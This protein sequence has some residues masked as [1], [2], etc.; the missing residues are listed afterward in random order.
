M[1]P[2]IT[3]RLTNLRQAGSVLVERH[4]GQ[5]INMVQAC[6]HS[7]AALAGLLAQEFRSFS[8]VAVYEGEPVVFLKRAQLFVSDLWGAFRGKGWGRF[9]DMEALTAFA[10][11]KLPQLL[12][13]YGVLRY[14]PTLAERIDQRVIIPAGSPEEVEIRAAT[15]QAVDLLSD[16]LRAE[17]VDVL[18]FQVDWLLWQSAQG[19]TMV[20]PYH[21]TRTI[22]Y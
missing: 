2:M 17:G 9:D 7:A 16:C 5:A 14:T 20:H 4:R 15:V 3:D 6:E 1:I 21:L 22:F 10:D 8:D 11:Y 19:M 18:P 13:E 12:R